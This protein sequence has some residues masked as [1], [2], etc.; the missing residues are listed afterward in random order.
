MDNRIGWRAVLRLWEKEFVADEAVVLL[1]L[2][3]CLFHAPL[4]RF[5]KPANPAV[6]AVLCRNVSASAL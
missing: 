5:A 2:A 1:L 3:E 6:R 4:E